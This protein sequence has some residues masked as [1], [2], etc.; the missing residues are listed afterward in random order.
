MEKENK[1]RENVKIETNG[2]MY[3]CIKTMIEHINSMSFRLF[4]E[5]SEVSKDSDHK[6]ALDC[7]A[8]KAS[9]VLR[10]RIYLSYCYSVQQKL[11]N[12]YSVLESGRNEGD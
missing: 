7:F 6:G 2:C 8:V 1:E 9:D 5:T 11:K 10:R 3:D 4:A 12:K